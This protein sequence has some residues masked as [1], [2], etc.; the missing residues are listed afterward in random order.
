L[1]LIEQVPGLSKYPP[2]G[3]V[4]HTWHT[5]MSQA[6]GHILKKEGLLR[7]AFNKSDGCF[8]QERQ[9]RDNQAR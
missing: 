2:P 9:S 8:C 3:T 1:D 6:A 7:Q 4:A 5:P